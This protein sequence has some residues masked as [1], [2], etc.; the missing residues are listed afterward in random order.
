MSWAA[1]VGHHWQGHPTGGV[2]DGRAIRM[3]T[4]GS[5]MLGTTDPDRLHR[6]YSTVLPPDSND[7]QGD[8]RILGYRGF[9][10]FIDGR[11][12]VQAT[13]PDP[14]RTIINFEVDDARATAERIEA[15]GGSWVAPPEDRDGSHFA[16]AQD[17]DGNYVQVIQ[18]SPEHL[19][20]MQVNASGARPPV[21]MVAGEAFSGFSVDDLAAAQAFYAD[22]LGLQVHAGPESMPL[23]NLDV[24][25]RKIL[26]YEK[27]ADHVPAT[28]TVLNLPVLDVEAAVRDLVGRGVEFVHYDGMPQDEL[29]IHRGGGPLI[30]WFS[31]PA[32]NVLSVIARD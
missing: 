25:G 32:G 14:A 12:D 9:Y 28:Y 2:H 7:V 20:E 5:I 3:A 16:T 17:P 21:G 26:V 15:L 6:W 4:L 30:A 13:H 24:G 23:L 19:A 10:L 11:D 1:A 29:G 22:V 8:Y 27:G 18:L 31:D